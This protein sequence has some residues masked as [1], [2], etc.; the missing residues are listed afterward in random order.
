[1]NEIL[2]RDNIADCRLLTLDA[3]GK[4]SNLQRQRVDE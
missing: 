3:A 2:E 4:L 1:M